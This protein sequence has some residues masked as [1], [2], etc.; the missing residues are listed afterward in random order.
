M[1]RLFSP[2]IW[3]ARTG[4][5]LWCVPRNNGIAS[6]P[7]SASPPVGPNRGVAVLGDRVFYISD[8]AYLVCLNRLTGAVMWSVWLPLATAS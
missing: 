5:P 8:D 3:N 4:A 6:A 1:D 7:K 2:P